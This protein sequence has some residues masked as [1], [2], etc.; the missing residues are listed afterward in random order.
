MVNLMLCVKKKKLC[1]NITKKLSNETSHIKNK[2][3]NK[4]PT[5]AYCKKG[6]QHK[7]LHLLMGS[8]STTS[9]LVNRFCPIHG[10]RQ[11]LPLTQQQ[12]QM[13]LS[14][15]SRA[16]HHL[17]FFIPQMVTASFILAPFHYSINKKTK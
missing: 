5:H 9:S 4:P 12:T 6:R 13:S 1:P 14:A 16:C 2:Q 7:H 17:A 15:P 10:L 3:T 8:Y 11:I